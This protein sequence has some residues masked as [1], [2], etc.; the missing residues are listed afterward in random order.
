MITQQQW[1]LT[2]SKSRYNF[3]SPALNA[4]IPCLIQERLLI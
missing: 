2:Y 4:N 3:T 1:Q